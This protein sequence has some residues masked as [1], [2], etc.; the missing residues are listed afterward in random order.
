[1]GI[2]GQSLPVFVLGF[3]T[4]PQQLSP[5]IYLAAIRSRL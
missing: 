5:A 2:T 3:F 1:V 4:G